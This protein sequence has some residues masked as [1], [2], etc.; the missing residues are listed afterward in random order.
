LN[1]VFDDIGFVYPDYRY[2]LRGQEKKRKIVASV[3]TAEPKGKKVKVLTHRSCYIELVII[4]EFGKGTSS[5]AEARQTTPIV[6]STEEPTVVPKVWGTDIPR[7][8]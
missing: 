3:N 2:P 6:Q 7:V 8:H 5:A 4:P 1:R